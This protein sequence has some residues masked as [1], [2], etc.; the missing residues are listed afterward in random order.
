MHGFITKEQ[1][2]SFEEEGYLKL[3]K[4]LTDQE[5]SGLSKRIDDIM[6]G[7]AEIDYERIMMQREAGEGHDR[8][9]QTLGFKG[10]TLNYRKIE[11]LEYD[12]LFLSFIQKPQFQNI[13]NSIYGKDSISCFRAM[14]MNKPAHHGALLA[15]HQDRWSHLTVDPLVTIW[16]ALDQSTMENGCLKIFP[17]TH[18]HLINPEDGS[19]FLNPEQTVQLLEQMKPVYVEVEAGESVL[20]HNWTVHGS[21]GNTSDKPRRAFSVCYMDAN[22][23]ASDGKTFSVVFG[24]G[25]LQPEQL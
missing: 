15:Y 1:W 8:S 21:D 2:K 6:T 17:R 13:C 4:V 9:D 24:P 18:K 7:K 10:P 5:L 20:L 14:F 12:S 19:G 25:A 23:T 22:T 3:G 16:T 11:N